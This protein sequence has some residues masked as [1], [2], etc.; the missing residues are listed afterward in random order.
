MILLLI[1]AQICKQRSKICRFWKMINQQVQSMLLKPVTEIEVNGIL[2]SMKSMTFTGPDDFSSKLMT[3]AALAIVTPPTKLIKR[4]SETGYFPE[5]M[6]VSQS[7]T[8]LQDGRYNFENYRP[9]SLLPVISKVIER[10]IYDRM[11]PYIY[12]FNLL[13]SNQLGFR[14]TLETLD[15]SACVREQSRV[16]CQQNGVLSCFLWSEKKRSTLSITITFWISSMTM[17]SEFWYWTFSFLISTV[18]NNFYILAMT[19]S[20][21]SIHWSVP[22]GSVLG[23]VLFILYINDL[24]D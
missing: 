19:S 18:G 17:A 10:A 5:S 24:P 21:R 20:L 8:N 4:Y 11:V 22:Q 14:Q 12:H 3:L 23:P 16:F 6:K 7:R 9:I 13:K 1:L 15:A 2:N